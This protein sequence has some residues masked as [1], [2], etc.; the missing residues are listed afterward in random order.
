M[1]TPEDPTVR[2]TC[3]DITY[4]RRERALYVHLCIAILPLTLGGYEWTNLLLVGLLVGYTV[5]GLLL[6]RRYNALPASEQ[7]ALR[8]AEHLYVQVGLLGLIYN[9]IFIY[10]ATQG[11][12]DAM[13]HLLLISALLCAGGAGVYQHLRGL[14]FTFILSAVAPQV[15]YY[16]VVGET[17]TA[18]LLVGFLFFMSETS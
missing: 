2:T 16:L 4:S 7:K 11:V 12:A 8:G 17:M 14:A 15:L 9:A 3:T 1:K 5:T 13:E 6:T 18:L 10:L